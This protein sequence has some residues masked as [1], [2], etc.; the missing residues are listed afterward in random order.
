MRS[1]AVQP[2]AEKNPRSPRRARHSRAVHSSCDCVHAASAA[3]PPR[4]TRCSLSPRP[5]PLA[6]RDRRGRQ[7]LFA[8]EGQVRQGLR[9]QLP[10]VRS[11]AALD[12]APERL[13]AARRARAP[14][15]SSGGS[16]PRR[17]ICTPS[18]AACSHSCSPAPLRLWTRDRLG[19]HAPLSWPSRSGRRC[20]RCRR[21]PRGTMSADP[22]MEI[23]AMRVDQPG[24]PG[25]EV[26]LVRRIGS[27]TLFAGVT[28]DVKTSGDRIALWRRAGAGKTSLLGAWPADSSRPMPPCAA[29]PSRLAPLCWPHYRPRTS[30][31]TWR[32]AWRPTPASTARARG[33]AEFQRLVPRRA[34]RSARL[35]R[36][37]SPAI[38]A[39]DHRA[40]RFH[41]WH[42]E[43]QES[44]FAQL[45]R[46]WTDDAPRVMVDLGCHAG[47]TRYKNVSD[48]LLWLHYFNHSG[49]A[50]LGVDAWEDP[51]SICS[52]G[53]TASRGTRRWPSRSTRSRARNLVGRRQDLQHARDRAAVGLVLHRQVVRLD[54]GRE[55]EAPT[56]TCAAS[57]ASGFGVRN[58]SARLSLPPSSSSQKMFDELRDGGWT[59]EP[60]NAPACAS[61]PS[62]RARR[63]TGGGSTFEKV[64]VDETWLAMGVE[65]LFAARGFAVMTIEVDASWGDV[66]VWN[67]TQTDQLVWLAMRHD[68]DV[69]LKVPCR[70][71]KK[72]SLGRPQPARPPGCTNSAAAA[73]P[74]C[75]RGTPR[76]SGRRSTSRTCSSPT[77]ACPSQAACPRSR[78]RT[79]RARRALRLQSFPRKR[80]FRFRELSRSSSAARAARCHR[81]SPDGGVF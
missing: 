65:G 10:Q 20:S 17:S 72:D 44:L 7:G 80:S 16:R 42:V 48:A 36:A 50:V 9:P 11:D 67:V 13:D 19:R 61:T 40:P 26:G 51:R 28:L 38:G 81:R 31:A 29:S 56:T 2:R 47:H 62:G 33:A 27:C 77:R 23:G 75:R 57:R 79:A 8:V 45:R 37:L 70:L 73:A 14:A 76:C 21:P 25:C 35:A 43:T 12:G 5:P 58:V 18:C 59:A 34:G 24:R 52:T 78:R 66:G 64:D 30:T 4:T 69:Y 49:G 39:L 71:G 46:I 60:Y 55:A 22:P 63:S 74:S 32:P 6:H 54:G 68:Y 53:S 3:P 1:A 15:S 41:R